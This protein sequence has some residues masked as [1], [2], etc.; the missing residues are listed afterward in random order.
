MSSWEEGWHRRSFRESIQTNAAVIRES[1]AAIATLA[2]CTS[3][4]RSFAPESIAKHEKHCKK[5]VSERPSFNAVDHYTRGTPSEASRPVSA[6]STN[7]PAP[8]ALIGSLLG[9]SKRKSRKSISSRAPAVTN[10]PSV[11]P[12]AKTPSKPSTP[13][14][15]LT[16][17]KIDIKPAKPG[18]S[19]APLKRPRSR[20]SSASN[21]T[22]GPRTP[23][24]EIVFTG[25]LKIEAD[26]GEKLFPCGEP[27]FFPPDIEG[28]RRVAAAILQQW[29]DEEDA[30]EFP[31]RNS[32]V[33]GPIPTYPFPQYESS[34][35]KGIHPL[36]VIDTDVGQPPVFVP[37]FSAEP[38]PK[39]RYD[40]AADSVAAIG[41]RPAHQST[42][43]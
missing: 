11:K 6:A 43:W 24:E 12:S 4:G 15:L 30:E 14:M 42:R 25:K 17:H 23:S 39:N 35:E 33:S 21:G 26:P 34:T 1:V 29:D 9:N 40:L 41:S 20:P 5:Q 7:R 16:S 27:V 31:G 3:C 38:K 37:K 18:N 28:A 2:T 8:T 32:T 10:R 13:T 36:S 19:S 22:A